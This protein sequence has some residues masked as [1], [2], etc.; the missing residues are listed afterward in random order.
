MKSR[1]LE[2]SDSYKHIRILKR[3]FLKTQWKYTEL[4]FSNTL[5]LLNAAL[6]VPQFQR[7]ASTCVKLC[8]F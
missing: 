2:H 6:L 7:P 3:T 4:I 8:K 5:C 1:Y